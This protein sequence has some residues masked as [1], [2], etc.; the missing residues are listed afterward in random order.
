M[1]KACL[2]ETGDTIDTE[3]IFYWILFGQAA[4]CKLFFY[5]KKDASKK[6]SFNSGGL[7]TM[8]V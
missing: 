6:G 2:V 1:Q 3:L 8:I 4:T 7:D 5:Q